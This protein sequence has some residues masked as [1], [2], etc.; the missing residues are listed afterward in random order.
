MALFATIDVASAG[1]N[2][3]IPEQPG[4]SIIVTAYVMV[5]AGTVTAKWEGYT[6]GSGGQPTQEVSG[7]MTMA[8]GTPLPGMAGTLQDP[9]FVVK[10][11]QA[12]CLVLS[13]GVQVSGHIAYYYSGDA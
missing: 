3:I 13:S 1:A 7:P 4:E 10:E 6:G 2:Q 5:A 9:L 12:L 8:A 11:N